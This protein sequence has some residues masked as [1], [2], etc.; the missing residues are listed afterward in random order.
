MTVVSAIETGADEFREAVWTD[1]ELYFDDQE[2]FKKALGGTTYRTWWL[3]K[4]WVMQAALA[5][6]KRFGA[7]TDDVTH[8]KTQML[9]GTFV[10]KAG[11]VVY[12]HHETST[13]DNGS[14]KAVLAAVLGK[15]VD[16]LPDTLPETPP[17]SE[18]LAET[19]SV[20]A[21]LSPLLAVVGLVLGPS[22]RAS[23]GCFLADAGPLPCGDWP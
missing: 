16:E 19:C 11:E 2:A 4:P 8:K 21:Y 5:Y 9:G 1:G 13:F 17:T 10:V 7:G 22:A 14:A 12:T 15:S 20:L 18:A 3:L 6:A 23:A